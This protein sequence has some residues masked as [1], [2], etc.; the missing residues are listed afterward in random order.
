[1]RRGPYIYCRHREP[2]CG[3]AGA[4]PG[5]LPRAAV[6]AVDGAGSRQVCVNVRRGRAPEL[7]SDRQPERGRGR[8]EAGARSKAVVCTKCGPARPLLLLLPTP[9]HQLHHAAAAAARCLLQARPP[10]PGAAAAAG[11]HRQPARRPPPAANSPQPFPLPMVSR[12]ESSIL[13]MS[14]SRIFFLPPA[15]RQ[16]GGRGEG[17]Q[18]DRA[19]RPRVGG[20]QPGCE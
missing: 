4:A 5:C 13:S 8:W 16:A 10:R 18:P 15:G 2:L 7:M 12:P 14:T 1:M 11:R 17:Q 3:A 9:C 6:R 20:R 19:C